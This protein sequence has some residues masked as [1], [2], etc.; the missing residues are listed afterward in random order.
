MTIGKAIALAYTIFTAKHIDSAELDTEA[1][2]AFVLQKDRAYILA[3]PEIE[4]TKDEERRYHTIIHKRADYVPFAYLVGK[5]EFYGREFIVNKYTLIP[6]PDTEILVDAVLTYLKT[7]PQK[8]FSL[9]DVG[10]GSGCIIIS[11]ACE[12]QNL[13]KLWGIDRV[14]RAL[15]VARQNAALYHLE[16]RFTFKRYNMLSLIKERFDIIVANLPYISSKELTHA[17]KVNPELEW[18]PQIALLGGTDGLLFNTALLQQAR[19]RLHPGGA[20]FFE[21]GDQ[22]AEYMSTLA[23][24]FLSPCKVEIKKDLCARDRV[25]CVFTSSVV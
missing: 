5:K 25:V 19:K 18:E 21:I 3:R 4:L 14:K 22:Q 23:E 8:K 13:G 17:R 16:D 9:I 15:D 24:K 7:N 10:T 20:V 1:L 12:A 6:R 11:L 2:L